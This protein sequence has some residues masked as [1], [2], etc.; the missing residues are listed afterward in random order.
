M[1]SQLFI[2]TFLRPT[3]LVITPIAYEA[4]GAAG[5][6]VTTV[7]IPASKVWPTT[8]TA[9]IYP[10]RLEQATTFVGMF[11][12]N[13]SAV[14]GN[15]DIGY[16]DEN[17]ARQWSSGST[18][19]AGTSTCQV[20]SNTLSVGPGLYYA[21]LN[22]DNTTATV[23]TKDAAVAATLASYGWAQQAVGALALPSTFTPALMASVGM[24]MF[25]LTQQAVI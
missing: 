3:S 18:A 1:G 2:P 15:F 14:S 17:Y 10:F 12:E 13:G 16:Y 20:V 21:A 8:N 4:M 9:Y 24:P 23:A 5:R 7:N 25:G 19:Q 6:D 11:V 22:F